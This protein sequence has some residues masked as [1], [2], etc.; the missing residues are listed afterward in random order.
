MFAIGN[1][2]CYH[3]I[4]IKVEGVDIME[5]SLDWFTSIPGL[6]ITGGVLLLLIALIIL[7]ATSGKK[8]KAKKEESQNAQVDPNATNM[9]NAQ[10]APAP[11]TN[12]GTVPE[13]NQQA[14][15]AGTIMDIPAPVQQQPMDMGQTNPMATPSMDMSNQAMPQPVDPMAQPM[16]Q[17]TPMPV[18]EQA[19]SMD[20]NAPVVEQ[21]MPAAA[22]SIEP[23][24]PMAPEMPSVAPVMEQAP[25]VQEMPTVTPVA[26]QP[27]PTAA[28]SIEP[29][30]PVTP[31][32]PSIAP[33]LEQPTV[34]EM[35]SVTPVEPQQQGPVI[36]GGANPIVPEINIQQPQHQIYGGANPLENTQSIPISNLVGPG[37]QNVV[38]TPQPEPTIVTQQQPGQPTNL[39]Q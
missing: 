36:Y 37:Q 25:V 20:M 28:P 38:Q 5:F 1:I 9:A 3:N 10:A 8:K 23:V 17:E 14:A 16:V 31:E 34:Q 30:Q 32:M 29:V 26:E 39:G 13:M 33:T 18:M 2:F 4:R 11:G 6:L 21:P 24:Q 22:P 7:I 35:P 15:S 12:P 19:P 27:M